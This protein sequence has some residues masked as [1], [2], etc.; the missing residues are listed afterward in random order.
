MAVTEGSEKAGL[1]PPV[2]ET[3]RLLLKALEIR[4]APAMYAY[5]SDPAVCRYQGWRPASEEEVSGFIREHCGAGFNL[6]DAWFQLGM[7]LKA[8]SELIG[9]LGLHFLAPDNRQMEIG[10]TV[11]PRHQRKGYAAEAVG[12][13]LP[14]GFKVLNK[15]R[16]IASVDP[17]NTASIAL[18][19]KMGMRK[20]AHFRESIRSGEGWADDL[21]FAVLDTEWKKKEGGK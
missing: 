19:G 18:L 13:L 9:D 3:E 17:R 12:V 2:I 8:T 16:I 6:V 21:I 20:E 4:D 11:A 5:R 1:R 7:Y 10:F 14:Y 15:H